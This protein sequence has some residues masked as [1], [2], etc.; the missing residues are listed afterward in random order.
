TRRGPRRPTRDRCPPSGRPSHRCEGPWQQARAIDAP[1]D[2]VTRARINTCRG[3][4][5]RVRSRHLR[6]GCELHFPATHT[7]A[8][9]EFFTYG[10]GEEVYQPNRQRNT[11]SAEPAFDR[12]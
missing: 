10:S 9:L 8:T 3:K 11:T 5:A 2:A 4:S 7:A 12:V 1:P 6:C